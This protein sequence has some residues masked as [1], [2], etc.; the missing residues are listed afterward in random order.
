M[1]AKTLK[2]LQLIHD[3]QMLVAKFSGFLILSINQHRPGS[4][5]RM[6]NKTQ[7]RPS[8]T[9]RM[10]N[11]TQHRP[12]ST[13]HRPNKTE[14]RQAA[15]STGQTRYSAGR[16]AQTGAGYRKYMPVPMPVSTKHLRDNQTAVT[17]RNDKYTLCV[18][19][20]INDVPVFGTESRT[21]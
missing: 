7:H 18:K 8:S 9:K 15:Q 16:P 5:K 17:E 13:K 12:S 2:K 10:S 3:I 1:K 21:T 20:I 6:S 19:V 14:Y 11:K 4:T